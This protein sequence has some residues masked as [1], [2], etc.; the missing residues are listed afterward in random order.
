MDWLKVL[1][2]IRFYRCYRG[3]EEQHKL[4]LYVIFSATCFQQADAS[5][6]ILLNMS[7]TWNSFAKNSLEAHVQQASLNTATTLKKP[8]T[9][10]FFFTDSFIFLFL[11]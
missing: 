11:N 9:S 4:L 5:F 6:M 3:L 7:T 2:R 10:R 8:K 1:K